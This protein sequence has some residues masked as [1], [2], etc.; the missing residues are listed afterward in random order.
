MVKKLLDEGKQVSLHTNGERAVGQ[1]LNILKQLLNPDDGRHHL[2]HAG[3]IT[4][5]QL[6]VCG[7]LGILPSFFVYQLYFYGKVFEE[8]TLGKERTNRWCPLS[9]AVKY[10]CEDKISIHEDHP[11]IPGPPFISLC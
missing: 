9:T 5:E 11:R 3:L 7:E 1:T 4:E 8:F 2:E 10:I 6:K